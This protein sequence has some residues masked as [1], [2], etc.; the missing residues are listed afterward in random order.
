MKEQDY[1]DCS[2]KD[3]PKESC[4]PE[5]DVDEK[6][7]HSINSSDNGESLVRIHHS[8]LFKT[9]YSGIIEEIKSLIK[10]FDICINE[11]KSEQDRYSSLLSNTNRYFKYNDGDNKPWNNLERITVSLLIV[12]SAVL[13][14]VGVNTIATYLLGSGYVTFI[15]KPYLAYVLATV[16]IG[17]A[18]TLKVGNSWFSVDRFKIIYFK[19]L[20]IVGI[21]M[22]L[23]WIITYSKLFPSISHNINVDTLI[24]DILENPDNSNNMFEKLFVGS[25]IIAEICIAAA[26]WIHIDKLFGEHSGLMVKTNPEYKG[27]DIIIQSCSNKIKS[28]ETNKGKLQGML[29]KIEAKEEL[30]ISN[31]IALFTKNKQD[32]MKSKYETYN[33]SRL[34]TVK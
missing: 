26:M 7:V 23:L 25:Q 16:N 17:L 34:K 27:Y 31:A 6:Y 2:R 22:G 11:R 29:A 10:V 20:W 12:V 5:V 28:A 14:F 24:M 3:I 13:L 32:V 9:K 15:E 1:I 18:F 21:I 4:F 30:L 19:C 33:E 8:E